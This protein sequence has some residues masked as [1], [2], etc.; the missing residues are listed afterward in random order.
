M[1][2]LFCNYEYPPLGGGGGVVN[3]QLAEELAKRHEVSVLTSQALGL[4]E[5]A[6]VNGVEV[7]RAPVWGRKEAAA[8]SMLSMFSYLPVGAKLGRSLLEKRRFDVI[9]THFVVP[10][11]PL[12]AYLAGRAGIPNVL[13][14]HGGDLYDPSKASSPHRHLVLRMLIRRLLKGADAVVGQSKNTVENVHKYYVDDLDCELIPLGIVRPQKPVDGRGAL[15]FGD[16]DKILVTV[17]R[18][19]ARKAVSQ[20]IDMVAR[21]DDP[22]LRLVIIGDGPK[23]PELEAQAG[24]LG[25]AD[26]IRFAGFVEEQ[27]KVDLLS[28]ADLY[29][30]TSQ[31]EGFG[32]VF[33]EAMAAGLPVVCYDFGGQSDFLEHGASG[34]LVTL[35]DQEAFRR[36]CEHLLASAELRERMSRDNRVRVEPF[37]IDTCARGYEELFSRVVA[38][39]PGR[40]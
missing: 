20:L 16:D 36:E 32:L 30:S 11:G 17:G 25:V 4:P 29:V 8:A 7:L 23:K 12:G 39:A 14:V 24:R 27:E 37:Y 3:A 5:Q 26:R 38:E 10:T 13:T 31:H 18:L 33:L 22:A 35:N 2:I 1:K 40:R 19:V 15:G 9:N 34:A 21:I 28:A 6:T